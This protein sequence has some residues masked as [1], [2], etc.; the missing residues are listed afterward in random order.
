[1]K[2]GVKEKYRAGGQWKRRIIK[3]TRGSQTPGK[4]KGPTCSLTPIAGLP[5]KAFMRSR[6]YK[7]KQ[8]EAFCKF[9]DTVNH[10]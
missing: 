4:I 1:M 7:M 10:R 3:K 6:A 9:T 8:Y 5:R 2:D